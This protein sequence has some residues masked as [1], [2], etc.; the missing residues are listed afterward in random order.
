MDENS[1][2]L[3][4]SKATAVFMIIVAIVFDVLEL[5]VDWIPAIGQAIS[6]FIDLT[7]TMIFSIWFMLK[8]VSLSDM[9][10]TTR[11]WL[12]N[13]VEVLP[14]PLIDTGILTIGIILMI[15]NSW[16]EDKMGISLPKPPAK[17]P[18]ITRVKRINKIPK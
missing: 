13:L 10:A 2:T 4:I 7:A 14:I 16:A 17:N 12:T 6:L 3:R 18:N 8:G 11:F 9:K 15:G 1:T 5:L